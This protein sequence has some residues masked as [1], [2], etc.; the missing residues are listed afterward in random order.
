MN[1]RSKDPGT[2]DIQRWYAKT[3]TSTVFAGAILFL[4]SGRL[5]WT[6]GW[7]YLLGG[8]L[9]MIANTIVMDPDLLA[10]RSKIQDGTKEWDIALAV[11]VSM[12]GPL[13]VLLVAGLDVRFGWSQGMGVAWQII[14][15][16]LFVLSGL[17]GTWA[18]ASNRYFSATVRIQSDR[19]HKV[20]TRGPYQYVRH[21]GYVGGIISILMT[22]I[23]LGS[24]LSLIPSI[25][26][27]C[28]YVIRTSLEDTVL[29][30]ELGG[31][32]EY[33]RTVRYRLVPGVW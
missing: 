23:V 21:P 17:L 27:A 3:M 12:L 32:Q 22:P 13:L 26:V 14:G 7:L 10:E 28:G 2:K 6:M 1:M 5:N 4:S 16:V 18:M 29:Q 8:I 25:L 11:F 9:L 30:Q 15:F 20:V 31:Y 33:A 19:N 24:W